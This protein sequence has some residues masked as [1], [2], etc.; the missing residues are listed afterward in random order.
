M[1]TILRDGLGKFV[2][3]FLDDILI[4]S[5]TREEH[6]QYL[7]SIL[8]RLWLEK[9]YE[10]LAKCGFFYTMVEYL[11]FN[12]GAYRIKPSLSKICAIAERPVL[13]CV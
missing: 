7:C 8:S 13:E 11:G 12:M 5:R 3:V 6:V 2:L 4:Y 1:N 9:F 10:R